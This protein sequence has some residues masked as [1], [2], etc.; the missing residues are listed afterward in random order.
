MF[1]LEFL[2][3]DQLKLKYICATDAFVFSEVDHA[4]RVV[5]LQIERIVFVGTENYLF[6][7]YKYLSVNT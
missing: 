6:G 1:V 5:Y 7:F 3:G 2:R 4:S